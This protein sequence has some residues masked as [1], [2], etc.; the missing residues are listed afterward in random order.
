MPDRYGE[1]PDTET[2][3]PLDDTELHT[4]ALTVP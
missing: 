2:Q 1:H 3:L 4:I